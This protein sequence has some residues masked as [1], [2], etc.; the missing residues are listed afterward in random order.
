MTCLRAD[1]T[2]VLLIAEDPAGAKRLG[3]ELDRDG[4]F[5]CVAWARDV[6]EALLP[7]RI[8]RPAV[9]LFEPRLRG[10]FHSEAIGRLKAGFPEA[11]VVVWTRCEEVG[12]ILR[13]L[14]Q[15]ADGYVLKG[16]T[17]LP[18]SEAIR[19][20]IEDD[21]PLSGRVVSLILGHLRDEVQMSPSLTPPLSPRQQEVARWVCDGCTNKEIADRMRISIDAVKQHI[22]AVKRKLAVRSRTQIS[23]WFGRRE[24]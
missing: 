23:G 11:R 18:V 5:A 16:D 6:E 21:P 22:A 24:E 13:A 7:A 1:P 15:G 2:A 12:Q 9:V 3:R 14:R 19:R 8:L 20:A 4:C 17:R 10:R